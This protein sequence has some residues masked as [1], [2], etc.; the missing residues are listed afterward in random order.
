MT[1]QTTQNVLAMPRPKLRRVKK[2]SKSKHYELQ[3]NNYLSKQMSCPALGKPM[4]CIGIPLDEFESGATNPARLNGTQE[5]NVEG[6]YNDLTTHPQ[7]QLEPGC[8]RFS[9]VTGKF[10]KVFGYNRFNS[11]RRAQEHG[12]SIMNSPDHV[13]WCYVFTGTAAEE[14]WLQAKENGNKRTQS[15]A[16]PQD[17]ANLIISLKDLGEFDKVGSRWVDAS[18][19]DQK[20]RIQDRMA[21]ELPKWS[22]RKFR[23]V[24]SIIRRDPTIAT[25]FT[26]YDKTQISDYFLGGNPYGITAKDALKQLSRD[27]IKTGDVIKKNGIRY[28]FYLVSRD[29]EVTAGATPGHV[30]KHVQQGKSDRII[31]ICVDNHGTVKTIV[32][33]R[34]AMM[35]AAR[36]WNTTF[37][38]PSLGKK[39]FC[40]ALFIS[41]TD[42]EIAKHNL[43]HEY[44]HHEKF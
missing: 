24:W 2:T 27:L 28:G 42:T 31:L 37:S 16:T 44:V 39:A 38:I 25:R 26:T 6:L 19:E 17:I 14:K 35:D 32:S 29:S 20:K 8:V 30:L 18:E 23:G 1:T 22:A 15:E 12:I 40:E 13:F 43:K 3:N 41:Q 9:K 7:G 34:Q 5:S 4:F 21:V 33:K 11:V 10:T 36:Y